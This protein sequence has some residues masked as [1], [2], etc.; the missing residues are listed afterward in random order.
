MSIYV[1]LR[2]VHIFCA[3]LWFGAPLGVVKLLKTGLEGGADTFRLAAAVGAKR[4]AMA[5][6]AGI[7]T[8]VTGVTIIIHMGGFGVVAS[9]I[10]AA[11]LVAVVMLG[12]SLAV[13]KPLGSQL[14]EIAAKKLDDEGRGRARAILK[15][16]GPITHSIHAMWLLLLILMYWR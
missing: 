8:L 14:S 2:V 9:Q 16:M 6:I 11:M 15:K 7:L 10:H 12:I 5:G 1:L 13:L 3:A 4:G